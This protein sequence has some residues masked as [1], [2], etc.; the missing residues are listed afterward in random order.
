MA[1]PKRPLRA[2]RNCDRHRARAVLR[3]P[4][5]EAALQTERVDER[6]TQAAVGADDPRQHGWRVNEIGELMRRRVRRRH[7]PAAA[8]AASAAS[9]H[10]N[11]DLM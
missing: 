5:L 3:V 6:R 9:S 4:A 2:E 8:S 1:R 10:R 7:G 11:E